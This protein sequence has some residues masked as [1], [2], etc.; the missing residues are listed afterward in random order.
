[1]IDYIQTLRAQLELIDQLRKYVA[2]S[3]KYTLWEIKVAEVLEKKF[4]PEIFRAYKNLGGLRNYAYP[5]S[6]QGLYL[7]ELDEKEQFLKE[8]LSDA[9]KSIEGT[10]SPVKGFDLRQYSLHPRIEEVSGKL[11]QDGS[12]KESIYAAYIEVIDR[13]KTVGGGLSG[14]SG[15]ELD[16]DKLV[17]ALFSFNDDRSPV[18]KLNEFE[19]DAD[20]D[21]QAGFMYLFKGIC[22]IRNKKGHK[23]F[24]QND[25]LITS[26]HLAL[27]SLLMRVL[28]DSFL[29]QYNSNQ[30]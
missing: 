19:D 11:F 6:N 10:I 8:I 30:E 16:G 20:K 18:I 26:E 7:E 5:E 3:P 27:A 29:E 22:Q 4:N 12:Y 24:L 21:E 2:D 17:T 13:L 1:M 23:N 14:Q 25:P 28:D 15:R 9:E